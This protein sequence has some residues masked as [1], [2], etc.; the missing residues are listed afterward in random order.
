[1]IMAVLYG[2]HLNIAVLVDRASADVMPEED[3]LNRCR[4]AG[5][6]AHSDFRIVVKVRHRC[7]DQ[8]LRA[9]GAVHI[10]RLSALQPLHGH[11]MS[12]SA[13]MVI[14]PM[15]YEDRAQAAEVEF[16][17]CEPARHPVA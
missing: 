4:A 10:D 15:G 9:G 16:Q 8:T 7:L 1:M 2:N 11:K 17:L 6:V 14:V 12:K 13:N 3:L 5:G